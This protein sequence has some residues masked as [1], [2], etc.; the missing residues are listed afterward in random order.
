M[1]SLQFFAS[2]KSRGAGRGQRRIQDQGDQG[3]RAEQPGASPCRRNAVRIDQGATKSAQ[4]ASVLGA[5]STAEL[6][7]MLASPAASTAELLETTMLGAG[8]LDRHTM[9]LAQSVLMFLLLFFHAMSV[10][11]A[12]VCVCLCVCERETPKFFIYSALPL[13]P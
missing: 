11:A 2:R 10:A 12:Q 8:S 9:A 3:A 13:A 5:G 7:S 1:K 6:A 4:L